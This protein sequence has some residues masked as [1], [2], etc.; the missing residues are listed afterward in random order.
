MNRH[1]PG[2]TT[3]R[4]MVIG[5]IAVIVLGALLQHSPRSPRAICSSQHAPDSLS[6]ELCV[7]KLS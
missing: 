1:N 6:W 5:W 3:F 7:H 4:V 2:R